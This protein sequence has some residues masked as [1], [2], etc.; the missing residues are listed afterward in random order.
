M[1]AKNESRRPFGI[2]L[3]IDTERSRDFAAPGHFRLEEPCAAPS[4]TLIATTV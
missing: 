4:F 2:R 1:L 3:G